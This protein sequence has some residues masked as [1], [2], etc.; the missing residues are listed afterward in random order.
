MLFLDECPIGYFILHICEEIV[1][2]LFESFLLTYHFFRLL[3]FL[4][5]F[6][7]KLLANFFLVNFEWAFELVLDNLVLGFFEF[8]LNFTLVQT[9]IVCTSS[10]EGKLNILSLNLFLSLF[11]F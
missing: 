7:D 1:D 10:F 3:L 8:D 5:N 2:Y 6:I 4:L 11:N 9:L